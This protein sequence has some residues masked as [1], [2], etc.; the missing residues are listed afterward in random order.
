[1]GKLK[2]GSYKSTTSEMQIRGLREES[3][4]IEIGGSL[5]TRRKGRLLNGNLS[6]GGQS[7]SSST[8]GSSPANDYPSMLRHLALGLIE[9]VP[10][11]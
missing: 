3:P 7:A 1:M 8:A 9:Q 4:E 6:G 5:D 10:A 11:K 2:S